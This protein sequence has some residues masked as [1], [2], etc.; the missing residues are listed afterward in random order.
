MR[1]IFSF[2]AKLT[3]PK[4]DFQAQNKVQSPAIS[5]KKRERTLRPLFF[6]DL[7]K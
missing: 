6:V 5:S 1:S 7:G 2:C 3:P 4:V